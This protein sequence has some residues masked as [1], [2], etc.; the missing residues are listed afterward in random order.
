MKG[1]HGIIINFNHLFSKLQEDPQ[2]QIDMV[3][4]DR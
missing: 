4:C 2:S 1:I 3:I